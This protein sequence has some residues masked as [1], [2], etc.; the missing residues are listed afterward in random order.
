MLI[1]DAT[2][3]DWPAIW[4]IIREVHAEGDTFCLDPD[5]TEADA[6]SFWM[7]D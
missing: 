7:L 3:A 1:R 2:D 6:R 4:G 5:L